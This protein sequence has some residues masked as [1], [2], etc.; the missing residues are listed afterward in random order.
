MRI[1]PNFSIE[2]QRHI[3]PYKNP[4]DFERRVEGMRKAGLP[5]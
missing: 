5:V 2:R 3:L 1:A 4:Y